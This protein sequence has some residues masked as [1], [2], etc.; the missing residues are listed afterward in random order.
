MNNY[1]KFN[2]Q[3]RTIRIASEVA[4]T[5]TL[6]LNKEGFICTSI[7]SPS[8]LNVLKVVIKNL[9]YPDVWEGIFYYLS[10]SSTNGILPYL[11][12]DPGWAHM[13][14]HLLPVRLICRWGTPIPGWEPKRVEVP[15]QSHVHL[16]HV[17]LICQWDFSHTWLS[18]WTSRGTCVN[19]TIYYLSVSSAYGI[20]PIPGWEP[21]QVE[22]P[23]KKYDKCLSV[24]SPSQG[25]GCALFYSKS[26]TKVFKFHPGKRL[27]E[28]ICSL[29]ICQNI[30]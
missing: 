11:A 4:Q 29:V 23:K 30:L 13:H 7:L 1:N 27:G 14:D 20:S 16:L 15:V 9:F 25:G 5:P 24:I 6:P 2:S 17:L 21:G 19:P 8:S 18:T 26:S 28:N 3:R 12:R 22:A 10:V